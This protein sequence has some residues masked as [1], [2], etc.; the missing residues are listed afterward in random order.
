MVKFYLLLI[1]KLEADLNILR[2]GKIF[3]FFKDTLKANGNVYVI[4]IFSKSI[5]VCMCGHVCIVL[6]AKKMPGMTHIKLLPTVMLG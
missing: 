1:S 2:Y 6:K 3:I 5:S 4:A